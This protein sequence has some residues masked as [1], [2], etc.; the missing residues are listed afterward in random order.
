VSASQSPSAAAARRA[1]KSRA[2]LLEAYREGLGLVGLAVVHGAVETRIVATGGGCD[3]VPPGVENAAVPWWCRRATDAARV[4]TTATVRLR[5]LESRDASSDRSAGRAAASPTDISALIEKAAKR[6]YV[7]LVT[8][9][10]ISAEAER[11]IARVDEEIETLRRAGQLKSVNQSYRIYR[12][13][14]AARGEKAAPYIDWFDKYRAKLVRELA[15]ALR[16]I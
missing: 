1:A 9:E 3:D 16:S 12:M 13:D 11:A 5:R 10:Q 6:L 2:M 4:A 7:V 14:A 15:A 8:D